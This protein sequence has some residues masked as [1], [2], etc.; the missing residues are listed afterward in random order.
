MKTTGA[1]WRFAR[2]DAA[3]WTDTQWYAMESF[4]LDTSPIH[5]SAFLSIRMNTIAMDA[6]PCIAA[7]ARV[8]DDVFTPRDRRSGGA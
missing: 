7:G 2:D 8:V 1:S 3:P 5:C 4:P 6:Y